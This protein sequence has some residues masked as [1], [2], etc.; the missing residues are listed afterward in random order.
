MCPFTL[1]SHPIVWNTECMCTSMTSYAN[2]ILRHSFLVLALAA[3]AMAGN[4]SSATITVGVTVLPTLQIPNAQ[5]AK[6][7]PEDGTVSFN[8]SIQQSWECLEDA[9]SDKADELV[10]AHSPDPLAKETVVV[11]HTYVLR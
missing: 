9:R 1:L 11:R 6:V 2:Q 7:G 4:S 3:S 8:F 5:P 10:P